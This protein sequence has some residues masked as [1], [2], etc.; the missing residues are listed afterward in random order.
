VVSGSIPRSLEGAPFKRPIEYRPWHADLF[1]RHAKRGRR[2]LNALKHSTLVS[3]FCV[4]PLTGY[5]VEKRNLRIPSSVIAV[6]YKLRFLRLR[7]NFPAVALRH[8]SSQAVAHRAW[9]LFRLRPVDQT[10]QTVS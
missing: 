3:L 8:P 6:S 7:Q 1:D 4:R 10:W 2:L 5:D 9:N